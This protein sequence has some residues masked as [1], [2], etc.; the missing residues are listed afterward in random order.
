[1][2]GL[3]SNPAKSSRPTPQQKLDQER[4]EALT[5]DLVALKKSMDLALARIEFTTDGIILDANEN[6]LGAMGYSLNEIKGKHHKMFVESSFGNSEE[7]RQ[8]WRRLAN[9]EAFP[10]Q[11]KRVAKGN[12]LIWIDATYVPVFDRDG[13]IIKV[14]KFARDISTQKAVELVAEGFQTAVGRQ[15]ALIEF[16]ASGTILTAN[17]NFLGIMGYSLRDIVGK[18]HSMFVSDTMRIS[19]EYSSFWRKLGLGEG[20]SGQCVRVGR[21]G[22]E[23]WLNASYNPILDIDGKVNRVVKYATDITEL[24]VGQRQ[25]SGISEAISGSVS[26]FSMTI[27]EISANV[28]RTASLAQEAKEIAGETCT[29]VEGLDESSRVIGKIVEVIQELADQTNLLALNATIES[30]RAGEAGRG[31]A[32]VA[33]A[34]K[35]L[36]KQT[37][38]ATKNIETTV[39]EIQK[40]IQGVVGSTNLISR[41]V[42]EVHSNMTTIAAAVEEQSVTIESI[43]RTAEELRSLNKTVH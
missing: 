33:S 10:G 37:A 43:N 13:T 14:I 24:V 17:D 29:L 25:S 30:A 38:A 41:S 5:Q 31:F 12:R 40:N 18:H 4:D 23:M 16:D 2:L 3:F 8:F 32:V 19:N 11:F 28:N 6:F 21:G 20:F 27:T 26:Q 42:S 1:M 34:V 15:F 7:Y 35:D 9:G 36:A 39:D 22:K